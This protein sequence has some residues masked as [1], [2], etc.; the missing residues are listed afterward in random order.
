M[1]KQKAKNSSVVKTSSRGKVVAKASI[2][3]PRQ[4]AFNRVVTDPLSMVIKALEN[5]NYRYRT[6]SGIAKETN[7][8]PTVVSNI[9]TNNDKVIRR[10]ILKAPDG[11]E[12]YASKNV[13]SGLEDFWSTIK[14][15]NN[16]KFGG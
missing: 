12:L 7:L 6:S 16:A 11:S 14:A 9:L 8:T 3:E 10:S 13:V 2:I 4:P 15:I 5:P 1:N